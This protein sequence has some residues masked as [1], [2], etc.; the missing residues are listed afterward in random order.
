LT[1]VISPLVFIVSSIIG[2]ITV[3]LSA[4]GPAK[5]AGRIPALDAVRNT[6]SLKKESFDKIKR[7][8]LSRKLY[9]ELK[10]K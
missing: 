4:L 5:Q 8:T 6:G 10:V 7:S 1:I 3:F 2:L 9:W